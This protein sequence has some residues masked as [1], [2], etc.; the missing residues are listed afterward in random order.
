M[1]TP[2]T[3]YSQTHLLYN[4]ILILQQLSY[5]KE[6]LLQLSL[7]KNISFGWLNQSNS[8]YMTNY[9]VLSHLWQF[10]ERCCYYSNPPYKVVQNFCKPLVPLWTTIPHQYLQLLFSAKPFK[11]KNPYHYNFPQLLFPLANKAFG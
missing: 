5:W 6:K 10:C 2:L 1:L 3:T 11:M 9:M 8:S 7:S 4:F